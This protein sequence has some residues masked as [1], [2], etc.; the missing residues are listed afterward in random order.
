VAITLSSITNGLVRGTIGGNAAAMAAYKS[1]GS[2]V[3][4]IVSKDG[5]T[6]SPYNVLLV[7]K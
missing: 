7:S 4:F 6:T 3:L 5:A 2:T 1:E